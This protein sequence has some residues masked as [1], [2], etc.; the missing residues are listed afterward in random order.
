VIV[1]RVLVERDVSLLNTLLTATAMVMAIIVGALAVQRYLVAFVAARVDAATL[2]FLVRRLL[3]L[4]M[5]YFSTRR[6]G[7]LQRRLEG[8][9][10]V[11]D[12]LVQ[13]GVVALTSSVQLAVTIVLMIVY[14]PTLALLFLASAPL[15]AALMVVSAK[16][17]RP[18]FERVEDAF[19]KYHSHQIDAIKG[20]E[21]VKALG[22]EEGFRALM[23]AEFQGVAR[24]L[25]R[26]DFTA[27]SYAGAIQT[28][29]LVSM[30]LF[31]W[32]GA[33]Q[34][35]DGKMTIGGLVAFNSL[36]ALATAPI[37]SLLGVWDNLQRSSVLVNRLNDVFEQEP[38]Q[39]VDRSRLRPVHDLDGHISLRNLGFRYGGPESPAIL[40]GITFEIPAGRRIALVG[41]SGSG[42][43][44]L[45]KCLAGLLEPTDGAILYDGI[46]LETLNYR[47]LRQ[48]IG[49]VLQDTYLFADTIAR[50]IAFGED[51]VDMERVVWAAGIANAKEFIERLPLTYETRIGETG[52][53]LSGGQRQRIAIARAI[54][55]RPPVL[56]LDEATSSLD[57][58]SER[59]VQENMTGVLEGRTSVVIA[60][61]L[62]TIRHADTILVL[63]Q[64]RLVEHGTHHELLERRG[65]YYYL[66]SEQLALAE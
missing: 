18:V 25:F 15:Y 39:G 33:Y 28:I 24:Q 66:S 4:P 2:D 34:V 16:V 21:T 54:Y 48:R 30:A 27:M 50:N 42:K 59:V 13:H 51:E 44:T 62:S 31:L 17:L 40:D 26:A 61:R 22:G 6:A 7:D 1:D 45:A 36:E 10:Q 43:T 47:D 35:M 8:A 9:R 55:R 12:F 19:G 32:V 53:A 41:R 64:G 49:F 52:I 58:E 20:I 63:E 11:R 60:H 37:I 3:S 38:E 14:S 56:I 29:T 23:L 46:G 5:T 65:L 57:T